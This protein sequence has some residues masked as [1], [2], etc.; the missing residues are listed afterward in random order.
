MTGPNERDEIAALLAAHR[1]DAAYPETCICEVSIPDDA[2]ESHFVG[3]LADLILASDWLAERDRRTAATALREA[4][5]QASDP[6]NAYVQTT[7]GYV[8]RWLRDRADRI[9]RGE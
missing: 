9:E 8:A 1:E 2:P 5:E 4:A 7:N 3:H 6:E